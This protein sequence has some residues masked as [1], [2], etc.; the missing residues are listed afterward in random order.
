MLNFLTRYHSFL[1]STKQKCKRYSKKL[2]SCVLGWTNTIKC[3][4]IVFSRHL[5]NDWY[6][7]HQ[8]VSFHIRVMHLSAIEALFCKFSKCAC[9]DYF[10]GLSEVVVSVMQLKHKTSSFA[11]ETSSKINVLFGQ[12][13]NYL[14]SIQTNTRRFQTANILRFIII[15]EKKKSFA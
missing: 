4:W 11:F 5:A 8:F 14:P 10:Y 2:F 3:V 13:V 7:V 6:K 1:V 15:F 12:M 9:A